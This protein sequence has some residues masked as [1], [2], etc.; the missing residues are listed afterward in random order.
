[1]DAIE[2]AIKFITAYPPWARGL[3]LVGILVSVLTL[4]FAPRTALP[5]ATAA[6]KQPT[7]MGSN[8]L[9]IEGVDVFGH[10][11]GQIQITAEVNGTAFVYPSL[12]GV[13]WAEVGPSMSSQQF[14]LPPS[15]LPLHLRF[16]ALLRP[17]GGQPAKLVSQQTIIVDKLPA[18]GRYS[19]YKN[20]AGVRAASISAAV[21]YSIVAKP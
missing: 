4:V 12:A 3:A 7:D 1:M 9:I 11:G 13:Q 19:L 15:Q 6:D 21:K 18:Q 2:S 17:S 20:Q 14:Q 10:E 16:T 8:W 5:N